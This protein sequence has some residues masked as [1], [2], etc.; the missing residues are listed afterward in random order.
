MTPSEA[1][2]RDHIGHLFK[3]NYAWLCARVRSRTG[4]PHSA[5]DIAAETFARILKLPDPS[6]LR[7]PKALLTTIAQR[8]M[9]EGWRRRDL[10][11]AYVEA[12]QHVPEQLQPAPEEQLMLIE[13]L[14]A[15]DQLLDGLPSQGKT[16]FVLSQIEGLTYTQISQRLELSLGSVHNY[17]AQALRCCYQVLAS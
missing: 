16:V 8:L 7:E 2:N 3:L 13:S 1:S 17:M 6:L 11:R 4:C 14:V 10:E 12:L 9:Y 5:E 15:I